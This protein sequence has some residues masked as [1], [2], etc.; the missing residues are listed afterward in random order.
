MDKALEP[1]RDA[2]VLAG[3]VCIILTSDLFRSPNSIISSLVGKG[4]YEN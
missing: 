4:Y 3:F 1:L 2:L